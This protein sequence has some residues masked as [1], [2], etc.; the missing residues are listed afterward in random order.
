MEQPN[1]KTR[2]TAGEKEIIRAYRLQGYSLS[3]IA[4]FTN[5]SL[6]SVKRTVYE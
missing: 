3:Q 5:R 6:S 2:M 4:R 1:G